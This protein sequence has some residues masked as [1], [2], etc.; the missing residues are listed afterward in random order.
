[1]YIQSL[2]CIG[3]AVRFLWCFFE[4]FSHLYYY[5]YL[6]GRY[7]YRLVSIKMY[8]CHARDGQTTTANNRTTVG[9]YNGLGALTASRSVVSS[10]CDGSLRGWYV[11]S[12][13]RKDVLRVC[14]GFFARCCYREGDMGRVGGCLNAWRQS[15][16]ILQAQFYWKYGTRKLNRQLNEIIR[17]P[18]FFIRHCELGVLGGVRYSFQFLFV[19]FSFS[20]AKCMTCLYRV[21]SSLHRIAP[22]WG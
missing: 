4:F 12:T 21:G 20:I 6:G 15:T 3:N 11:V 9:T 18:R 22:R 8:W 14:V 19:Y 16:S 1:M 7:R 2:K 17:F 13:L 10:R 5:V